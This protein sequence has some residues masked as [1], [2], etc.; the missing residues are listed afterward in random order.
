M[1]LV[2]DEFGT[3]YLLLVIDSAELHNERKYLP[4]I[5]E[6]AMA[7]IDP[8]KGDSKGN[9]PL[10]KISHS[11]KIVFNMYCPLNIFKALL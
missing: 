11:S 3:T 1:S 8:N 7:G 6:L 9:T 10:C 2:D 5:H 4:M